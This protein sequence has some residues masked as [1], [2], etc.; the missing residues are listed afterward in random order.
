MVDMQSECIAA[1]PSISYIQLNAQFGLRRVF[2]TRFIASCSRLSLQNHSTHVFSAHPQK[3]LS[4][5]SSHVS[6]SRW[7]TVTA[8][9]ALPGRVMRRFRLGPPNST[10][11]SAPAAASPPSRRYHQ[12]SLA[13]CPP[14]LWAS[15]R[16]SARAS[17][18]KYNSQ[19]ILAFCH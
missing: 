10:P 14:T 7:G 4:G 9:F 11:D 13:Q 6:L 3:S 17:P 12:L 8:L 19:S 1:K 15:R 16:S 5:K 18:S 2:S